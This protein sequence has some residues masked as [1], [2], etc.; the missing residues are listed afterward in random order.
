ME[1]WFIHLPDDNL[2]YLSKESDLFDDYI[3]AVDW[4]QEYALANRELMMNR[5]LDILRRQFTDLA[6]GGI[7]VNCHHNYVAR[8]HH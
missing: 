2:A 7:A 5:V 3:E 8:E 4:A 6:L 1:R